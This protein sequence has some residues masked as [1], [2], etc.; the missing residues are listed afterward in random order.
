M[1]FIRGVL[2]GDGFKIL[3]FYD[4]QLV[5]DASDGFFFL[6]QF[7]L[8]F[9]YLFYKYLFTYFDVLGLNVLVIALSTPIV[10]RYFCHAKNELQ[11][12]LLMFLFVPVPLLFLSSYNK[13]FVLVVFLY[14]SYG[15]GRDLLVYSRGYLFLVYAVL[16][17][18]YLVFV[19]LIM[20]V[21][22]SKRFFLA[23]FLMF[24][25]MASNEYTGY[26]IYRLFNRRLAE[27]GFDANSEILQTVE[28]SDFLSMLKMLLEVVP[29]V[30]MPIFYGVGLKTIFFQM[31]VSV[32]LVCCIYF[33]SRY[34]NVLLVLF[35]FYTILDPDL[36]AFFRHLT[37]F[38]ILFPLMLGLGRRS[39]KN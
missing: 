20:S 18:A 10:Y 25:G 35:I 8:Y 28:V 34:S 6:A 3:D 11:L 21:R 29:Q 22:D 23:S 5:T 7:A 38:F 16:M 2:F 19:P 30:L 33:R 1:P 13:D 4:G 9:P 37:S 15:Y 12:V 39:A 31:Y 36:G 26:Y 24:V 32:F 17:R 14:F 27:K